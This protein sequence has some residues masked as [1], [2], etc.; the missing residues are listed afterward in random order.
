MQHRPATLHY[1]RR[2]P[3]YWANMNSARPLAAPLADGVREREGESIAHALILIGLFSSVEFLVL[4][5][6]F[7]L[8]PFLFTL[9]RKG[10]RMNG[11]R[12]S[13]EENR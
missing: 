5:L 13:P 7:I 3:P 12:N 6:L 9:E 2:T 4:F 1:A 10:G 8:P 11:A